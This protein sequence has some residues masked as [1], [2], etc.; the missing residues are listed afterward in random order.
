M[1]YQQIIKQR[2]KL[3]VISAT[4]CGIILNAIPQPQTVRLTPLCQNLSLH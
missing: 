3:A 2:F 4:P 1:L